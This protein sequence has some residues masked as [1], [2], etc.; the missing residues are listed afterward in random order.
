MSYIIRNRNERHK[1]NSEVIRARVCPKSNCHGLQENVEKKKKKAN[2]EIRESP[3]NPEVPGKCEV[4][5]LT[6]SVPAYASDVSFD[7]AINA[8]QCNTECVQRV[9][10]EILSKPLWILR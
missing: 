8:A 4:P 10:S 9:V 1:T 6:F 3:R 7:D 2:P 5:Q